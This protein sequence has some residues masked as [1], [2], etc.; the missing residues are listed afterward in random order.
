MS[1]T[2]RHFKI[3]SPPCALAIFVV[4]ARHGIPWWRAFRRVVSA[5]G[6]RNSTSGR[7]VAALVVYLGSLENVGHI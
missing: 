1:P 5:R 2:V 7:E 4:D 3:G 6:P